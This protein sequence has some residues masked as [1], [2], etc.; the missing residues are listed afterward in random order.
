MDNSFLSELKV[1]RDRAVD[2]CIRAYLKQDDPLLQGAQRDKI[3]QGRKKH[4][5]E[6]SMP[7]FVTVHVPG[8]AHAPGDDTFEQMECDDIA[9][10]GL[11]T[12]QA[13]R[14]VHVECAAGK[15]TDAR[16]FAVEA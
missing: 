6:T 9:I 12:L 4:I 3:I 5:D 14:T 13:V 10:K 8:F 7:D 16:R 11:F 1:M 15:L 2:Q